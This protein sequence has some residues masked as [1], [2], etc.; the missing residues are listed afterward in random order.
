MV[1]DTLKLPRAP[2][3][4]SAVIE[5]ILADGGVFARLQPV[6]GAGDFDSALGRAC[7]RAASRLASAGTGIDLVTMIAELERAGE[8]A[9]IGGA[10]AVA[11]LAEGLADTANAEH[12]AGLV[13]AA[14]V[15][16]QAVEL[17]LRLSRD[18]TDPT[19]PADATLEAVRDALASLRARLGCDGVADDLAAL[20][21]VG[22]W[23]AREAAEQALVLVDLP[24][25]RER[26]RACRAEVARRNGGGR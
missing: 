24:Q 13:K 15:R 22:L 6:I 18:A 7:W 3:Q 21:T 11:E 19:L 2:R 26:V 1:R 25:L 10:A 17:G 5:A 4:E 23:R 9:A 12:Y 14:S 8:L 20:D 16:R